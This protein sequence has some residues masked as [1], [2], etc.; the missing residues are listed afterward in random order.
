MGVEKKTYITC[1]A[2]LIVGGDYQS[3]SRRISF[4]LR[5]ISHGELT[6]TL[7]GGATQRV[8][9]EVATTFLFKGLTNVE[10]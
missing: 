4:F 6:A 5:G 10:M 1:A 8:H 7:Y 3:C 9:K 2:R